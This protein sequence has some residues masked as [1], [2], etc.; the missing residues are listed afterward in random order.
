M[1]TSKTLA[2]N[3]KLGH[4]SD[5]DWG[6]DDSHT[7]QKKEPHESSWNCGN[8]KK[9]RQLVERFAQTSSVHGTHFICSKK[10]TSC[11]LKFMYRVLFAL[12]ILSVLGNITML[13]QEAFDKESTFINTINKDIELGK[14]EDPIFFPEYPRIT[15]CRKPFYR[16][17]LNDSYLNLVEYSFLALGY[18]FIPLTPDEISMVVDISTKDK[19]N[20]LPSHILQFENRLNELDERFRALRNISESF[21]LRE[22]VIENSVG[23]KDFFLYCIALVFPLDCCKIFQPVLTSMGLCYSLEDRSEILDLIKKSP[24]EFSVIIDLVSP[25][26][27]D[28][29]TEEGFNVFMTDPL[30]MSLLFQPSE[31]QKIVPGLL[32]SI[33]VQ[34]VKTERSALYTHWTSITDSCPKWPFGVDSLAEDSDRYSHRVCDTLSY[35]S[36]LRNACRCESIFFPG[37]ATMRYCEPKDLYICF[38]GITI[39]SNFSNLMDMCLQPCIT[40]QYKSEASYIGLGGENFSRLEIMYNSKQFV[41][42][43]YRTATMSSLFSQIGGSLGLYLGA[44]IITVVEIVVFVACWLW[45]R[46]CPSRKIKVHQEPATSHKH[47]KGYHIYSDKK[48]Y[49]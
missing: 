19:E 47:H 36:T 21:N 45:Y 11:L 2:W 29:E 41:N 5:L 18:P 40:Y 32:T 6:F 26:H 10:N 7:H 28:R 48:E 3:T 31:G 24:I 25:P 23:C 17:D 30:E 8:P 27:L 34:L 9:R 42:H 39:A 49:F 12:C 46:V 37:N 13:L 4:P 35:F 33:N 38:A 22:F 44:S 43:E 1:N 14:E 15:L 16:T 20:E